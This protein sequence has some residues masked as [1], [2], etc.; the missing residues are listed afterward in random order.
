MK[1]TEEK[2]LYYELHV[3]LEDASRGHTRAQQ[4]SNIELSIY[5]SIHLSIYLSIYLEMKFVL[6]EALYR[7]K[8]LL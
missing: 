8:F 3:L 7:V 4:Y 1:V 2:E 5:P 6:K